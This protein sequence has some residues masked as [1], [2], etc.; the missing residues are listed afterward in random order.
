M[1]GNI[2]V[3]EIFGP[4]IQGEGVLTGMLTYFVRLHGCNLRCS[5]FFQKDPADPTTYEIEYKEID[6]AAIKKIEDLPVVKN[7]CDSFYSWDPKFRH[8]GHLYESAEELA[9]DIKKDLPGGQWYNGKTKNQ[10][11]LCIT[12][13]EPMIQQQKII[14]IIKASCIDDTST[15]QKALLPTIQ[16]ETNGTI[17]LKQEFIDFYNEELEA[18]ICFNVSPKLFYVSGEKDRVD[19]DVI[20]SYFDLTYYGCLKFVINNDDRAWEELNNHVREITKRLACSV[21]IYVMPVG[22]TYEQQSDSEY[23]TQIANRAIK[24]GYHISGRLH[25][26]IWGNLVGV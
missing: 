4:T 9:T 10:I 11:S 14:K 12:G 7:G 22:A 25:C 17:P 13:G 5:G 1:S 23:L 18:H 2:R 3:S 15:T 8:L 6:I 21:P 16:I 20:A 26:N 19:Y 24:E